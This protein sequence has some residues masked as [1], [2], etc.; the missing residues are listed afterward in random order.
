[1]RLNRPK[2]AEILGFFQDEKAAKEAAEELKRRKITRVAIIARDA[3]NRL[4]RNGNVSRKSLADFSR[5]LTRGEI[6]V[7][8]EAD[9]GESKA[10]LDILR[11]NED[12]LPVTFVFYPESGV[13]SPS[14]AAFVMPE[15][16]PPDRLLE[17]ARD[18]SR[19]QTIRT[20]QQRGRPLLDN[21]I[22]SEKTLKAV[23]QHLADAA[24]A[25]QS[26][27]LSAEWLLDNAYIIQGHIAD[28]K[29]NLPRRYYEQLPVMQGGK[30]DGLPRAYA[31]AA[32]LTEATDGSLTR[33]NI[34]SFLQSYQTDT[35]LTIGELWVFPLMLRLSLIERLRDLALTVDL[36]QRERELGDFWANR[37]LTAARRDPDQTLPF[38]TELSREY[39]NPTPHFADQLVSHLYDEEAALVS[40]QQW[41]ERKL[42]LPLHDAAGQD[43]RTQAVQQIALGNAI[44]SLRTISQLDWR[45]TFEA[46]SRVDHVLSAD[47]AG[48][49][50][51]MSF[52]TRDRYRHAV[53]EIARHS[54]LSEPETALEVLRLADDQE[55][56]VKHHVGYFLIDAGLPEL[57]RRVNYRL[58]MARQTRRYARN[59]PTAIY[60][61]AVSAVSLLLGATLVGVDWNAGA[62]AALILLALLAVLPVSEI[63]VQIVNYLVT[64]LMP[65][66]F[67]PRMSFEQG[68]PENC[69]SLVVV[70]M[71]LLTPA[72]IHEELERLEIRYLANTDDNLRYA[73]L[74]DFSDAPQQNMPEDAELLDVAARAVERLNAQY[75]EGK[76]FLFHRQREWSDS[77]SRWMGWERKRGKLEQLN[78][79][80]SGETLPMQPHFLRVGDPARLQE[81]PLHHHAGLAIPFCPATRPAR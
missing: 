17:M 14:S 35:A 62:G 36:R 77:E 72:S 20:S 66:D 44:N 31:L 53:E 41:L 19:T 52:A 23:R 25:D 33:E 74:S 24:R 67:L 64:R 54:N 34:H 56:E 28:F 9:I 58:P 3:N 26:L 29:R 47:P 10:L 80:L 69:R 6:L 49:Y 11:R 32:S 38:L 65:P 81:Y 42:A 2:Q 75:G 60:L 37:L 7:L 43:Q 30:Y 76:F 39:P 70:P 78:A 8:A 63:A 46:V 71:M 48:I 21:L 61:G 12:A 40:A 16:L 13:A 22:E 68:I 18:L 27:L 15:P 50:P 51:R 55:D 73:L 57:E 5:W 4:T 45:E 59:H 79:Y 1:M